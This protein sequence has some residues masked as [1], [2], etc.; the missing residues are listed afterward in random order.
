MT[1]LAWSALVGSST[2]AQLCAGWTAVLPIAGLALLGWHLGVFRSTATGLLLLGGFLTAMAAARPVSGLV[3]ALGCP[4]SQSLAVS[5]LFVLAAV[6]AGGRAALGGLVP[7]AAVR[8]AP[9]VD[10]VG[11]AVLGAAAGVILGGAL[12]VGWSMA[13]LPAWI[14]LDNTHQPLDSGG[15]LIATFAR[16]A[17]GSAAARDLLLAGDRPAAADA[18]EGVIRASEPFADI[19]G[20]GRWDPGPTADTAGEPY[21]DADGDGRFTPDLGWHDPAGDG[22]RSAGLRDCYRLADWRRVRCM[23]APRIASPATAEIPENTPVE[24]IVYEA[25]AADVD[26][27]AVTFGVEPVP[28]AG[29]EAAADP[30]VTIDPASGAVRLV[31]PADYER[32]PSHEFVVVATDATGLAARQRVRIRVRDVS[33]EPRP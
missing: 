16:F 31:E 25:R 18:E 1:C 12:L 5:Y 7:E 8:V 14:R 26:G 19:D 27:D 3:E 4:A 2:L 9:A 20:D 23:H 24:E 30:G 17:A 6:A 33:L 28:A 22:R 10:R 11:G 21:L 13:D 15:R 29:D 32:A